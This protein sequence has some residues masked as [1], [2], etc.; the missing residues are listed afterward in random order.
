MKNASIPLINTSK[1]IIDHQHT[2]I[3]VL[4]GYFIRAY[5]SIKLHVLS[6]F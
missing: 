6:F 3:M 1:K 5:Q 4:C 2:T